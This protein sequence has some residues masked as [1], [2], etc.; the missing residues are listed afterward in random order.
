MCVHCSEYKRC[1]ESR[2]SLLFFIIGMVSTI[3]VRVVTVLAHMNPVY[4]EIA[5]YVGV[6]GFF[7]YFVYKYRV[8]KAR[9]RL[10]V[11]SRLMEKISKKEQIVDE[12][13]ELIGSILCALSS[14]KDRINYF[15]IFT[16][17]ALAIA[18][19]LYFDLSK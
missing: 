14:N 16:T 5:W 3:A 8:D 15:L 17:S 13:R 2:A 18:I 4:G 6:F 11:K 7:V 10:I 12:D 9:Y 19:A 1:R